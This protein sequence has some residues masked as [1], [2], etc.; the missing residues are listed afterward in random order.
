MKS[1]GEMRMFRAP[2]WV[3]VAATSSAALFLAVAY[4]SYR[5]NGLSWV[6][7]TLLVLVPIGIAGA[8]DALTQRIELYSEHIVVVNN[9]RRREYSRSMFMKVQWGKGVPVSLQSTSGQW[10]QLPGVGS[11]A[12]GLANTLRA[13]LQA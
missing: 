10:I 8:A 7:V 4:L 1:S 13:W 5:S 3:A 11:S 2:R 12:Q 9:L 6:T